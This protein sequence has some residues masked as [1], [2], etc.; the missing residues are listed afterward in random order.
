MLPPLFQARDEEFRN[1]P[2]IN[3]WWRGDGICSDA[4]WRIEREMEREKQLEEV[5]IYMLIDLK[6]VYIYY[7]PFKFSLMKLFSFLWCVVF[8]W[9][10]MV[11]MV[12]GYGLWFMFKPKNCQSKTPKSLEGAKPVSFPPRSQSKICV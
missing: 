4:G 3:A 12:Y 6:N 2:D 1:Y 5:I 10:F 8:L 7:I 11:F 9:C